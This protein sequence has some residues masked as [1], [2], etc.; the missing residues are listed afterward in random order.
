VN[1]A[2][3]LT[4]IGD[5]AAATAALF[6]LLALGKAN[7]AIQETKAQRIAAEG[8]SR[9][10]AQ[11]A[12]EAAEDRRAA[13]AEARAARQEALEASKEASADRIAAAKFAESQQRWEQEQLLA[14][15]VERVG[16]IVEDIFWI[17]D[18]DRELEKD[19]RRWWP[20]R[21]R[22]AHAMVGLSDRLPK[23]AELLNQHLSGQAFGVAS[24]ARNQVEIELKYLRHELDRPP[25]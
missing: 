13:N 3:V 17:A 14:E 11:A 25:E 24:Q 16:E 19:P 10:A 5:V 12:K 8:A 7:D 15:R 18:E 1:V 2:D 6:A 21:N 4:L 23:C 20:L 9:E 22:L